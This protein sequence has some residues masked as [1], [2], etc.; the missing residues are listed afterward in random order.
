MQFYNSKFI[1]QKN[2]FNSPTTKDKLI[3]ERFSQMTT[4][5]AFHHHK[6]NKRY[7]YNFT[8]IIGLRAQ[9]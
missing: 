8:P 3:F 4:N 9:S 2:V 1:P 6:K 7:F 5:I